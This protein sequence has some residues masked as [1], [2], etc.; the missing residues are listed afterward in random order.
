MAK[1][2]RPLYQQVVEDLGKQIAS[3]ELPPGSQLPVDAELSD[4]YQASRS[5]IREA[6]KRLVSQ[7]LLETRQGQG[8]FVTLRVEPFVTVLTGDPMSGDGGDEGASYLSR[9][10]AEHRKP[11]ETTPKV[12]V[13]TPHEGIIKRLRVPAGTQVVSR[14]QKRYIDDVPW[15]LQTSFYPMDLVV[16]GATELLTAKDIPGGAVR[17][18][19]EAIDLRQIG[20]RDWITARRPDSSEQEFF[21]ISHDASVFEVFRTA[22]DQHAKPMRVTVTIFPADRNQFIV[23]VG[24]GVPI[25]QYGE[26]GYQP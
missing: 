25:P 12:E 1:Q 19:E 21:E 8:T 26:D 5:T 3:G 10:S 24:D 6:I 4:R 16:R 17:Y 22:F 15:S 11:F 9:V 20:Y 18:I 2:Q 7:G 14:H 23:N 13:Q